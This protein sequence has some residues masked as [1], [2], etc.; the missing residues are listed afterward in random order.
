MQSMLNNG[1]VCMVYHMH[2]AIAELARKI[3]SGINLSIKLSRLTWMFPPSRTNICLPCFRHSKCSGCGL[4]K[5]VR[6]PGILC[7]HV[8]CSQLVCT[9]YLNVLDSPGISLLLCQCCPF[10]NMVC[11][12][13]SL[14][15]SPYAQLKAWWHARLL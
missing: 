9:T 12:R 14:V 5:N 4:R 2:R 15:L 3:D 6:Y 11:S 7:A 13:T 10:H 8:C 1:C